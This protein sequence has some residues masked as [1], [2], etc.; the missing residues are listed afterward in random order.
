MLN[1]HT[2]TPDQTV[3]MT[4]WMLTD[5]FT[6]AFANF[7]PYAALIIAAVLALSPLKKVAGVFRAIITAILAFAV[8]TFMPLRAGLQPEWPDLA[9]FE[10]YILLVFLG[11]EAWLV[12]FAVQMATNARPFKGPK[13]SGKASLAAMAG[14]EAHSFTSEAVRPITYRLS[15]TFTADR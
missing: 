15:Q 9:A 12:G 8:H 11:F 3:Q 4:L 13:P 6:A 7:S 5:P 2:L 14:L 10:P 1:M